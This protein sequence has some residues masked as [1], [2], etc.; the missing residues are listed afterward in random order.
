MRNDNRIFSS[1]TGGQKA[2]EQASRSLRKS[3]VQPSIP[4]SAQLAA[5]VRANKGFS[6]CSVPEI[7][8]LAGASLRE[9]HADPS[10]D[11]IQMR[12]R[13][14]RTDTGFS[15]DAVTEGP[16]MQRAYI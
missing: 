3:G 8:C 12:K 7:L 15:G 5:G 9:L 4:C 2:G 10:S 11:P 16:R 6:Q 14:E 1:D 13:P